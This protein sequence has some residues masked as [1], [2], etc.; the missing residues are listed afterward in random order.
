MSYLHRSLSDRSI[1]DRFPGLTDIC[2]TVQY[3]AWKFLH[4]SY[5]L[6]KNIRDKVWWGGVWEIVVVVW[7]SGSILDLIVG[8]QKGCL[9][10]RELLKTHV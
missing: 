4:S 5:I 10:T 3:T 2:Y 6:H 8:W 9:I 1:P 7:I